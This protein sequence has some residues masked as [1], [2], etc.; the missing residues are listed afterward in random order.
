MKTD[1]KK[2]TQNEEALWLELEQ[3]EERGCIICLNGT[4]SV[5][6]RIVSECLREEGSYMRDFVSDDEKHVKKIDF[7]RIRKEQ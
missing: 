3:Y 2:H 7:V 1:R 5:P 4:P 6:E